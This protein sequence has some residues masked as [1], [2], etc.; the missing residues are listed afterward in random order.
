[1]K[2]FFRISVFFLLVA[3]QFSGAV[4]NLRY[5]KDTYTILQPAY[6]QLSPAHG[7]IWWDKN[8]V[9]HNYKFSGD[10]FT[11]HL[12]HVPQAPGAGAPQV[13]DFMATTF[14]GNAAV[15][16]TP[17]LMGKLMGAIELSKVAIGQAQAEI[18][19]MPPQKK[20]PQKGQL[21]NK[22]IAMNKKTEALTGSL[23]K[24]LL[25]LCEKDTAYVQ[26]IESYLATLEEA[27]RKQT[28]GKINSSLKSFVADLIKSLEQS[29]FFELGGEESTA[30]YPPYQ[31]YNI[32]LTYLYRKAEDFR[33]G[34]PIGKADFKE[35]FMGLVEILGQNIFTPDGQKL[36]EADAWINDAYSEITTQYRDMIKMFVLDMQGLD[37]PLLDR[38]YEQMVYAEL[39]RPKGLPKLIGYREGT[40]FAGQTLTDCMDTL[41]RNLSNFV[42]YDPIHNLFTFADLKDMHPSNAL[43]NFYEQYSNPANAEVLFQHDAW[44]E[45]IQNQPYVAYERIV[46]L[47]NAEAKAKVGHDTFKGFMLETPALQAVARERK[48]IV[49]SDGSSK[50][51]DVAD[52]N[53]IK[54][55]L[56]DPA[57]YAAYEVEPTIRNIIVTMN[58]L[59]GLGLY[60]DIHTA[61]FEPN[62]NTK[63][64]SAMTDKLGWIYEKEGLNLNQEE[65]KF[66]IEAPGGS[67]AVRLSWGH[68]EITVQS[69]S[70]LERA[71]KKLF[72]LISRGLMPIAKSQQL[73]NNSF[74]I[75]LFA[76]YQYYGDGLFAQLMNEV[77]AIRSLKDFVYFTQNLSDSEV[78]ISIIRNLIE[79]QDNFLYDMCAAL[80]SKLDVGADLFYL[81]ELSKINFKPIQHEKI[82]QAIA[83]LYTAMPTS[84]IILNT[85]LIAQGFL[86]L[87]MFDDKAIEIAQRA[88]FFSI[89]HDVIKAALKLFDQLFKKGKGIDKAIV[90]A[91]RLIAQNIMQKNNGFRLLKILVNN[92]QAYD[93]ALV[94]AKNGMKDPQVWEI[95]FSLFE[96]LVEQGHGYA[97]AE[98]AV[99][100][101]LASNNTDILSDAMKVVKR[102][103]AKGRAYQIALELAQKGIENKIFIIRLAALNLFEQ[104]FAQGH[105]YDEAMNTV[106]NNIQNTNQFVRASALQL[107]SQ[108]I[109]H[110]KF[111]NDALQLSVGV[112]SRND[113]TIMSEAISIYETLLEKG[114]GKEISL[115]VVSQKILRGEQ[116]AAELLE[117]LIEKGIGI[118]QALEI[119]KEA[120]KQQ[121]SRG[122]GMDLFKKLFTVGV[123]KEEAL[124]VI[125][126]EV[127][128]GN[129]PRQENA[130]ELLQHMI[131]AFPK[132]PQVADLAVQ[133][134]ISNQITP[135]IYMRSHVERLVKRGLAYDIALRGAQELFKKGKTEG[136]L[137]LYNV[138]VPKGLAY[139]EALAAATR[140]LTEKKFGNEVI[141][142][143]VEV[144]TELLAQKQLG[145]QQ[146]LEA[147]REA[148]TI[149]EQTRDQVLGETV[150]RFKEKIREQF[151]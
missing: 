102:L 79:T 128:S 69:K 139:P 25:A 38:L 77:N 55:V 84:P 23:K 20:L 80:I 88:L 91:R 60:Q 13:E 104:L 34:A 115:E 52:V 41:L 22:Q 147:Y 10:Q 5:I 130:T 27:Q 107:L 26:R 36:F 112:I 2:L 124:R 140:G 93:V 46:D 150:A 15:Y 48:S 106:K 7:P 146:A 143:A 51:F 96:S 116:G 64:F 86:Y 109:K 82:I 95:V 56:I 87:D 3:S 42:V 65:L 127:A 44:N 33:D 137:E 125:G 57:H 6:K 133:L 28:R 39:S 89:D 45:V 126:D 90:F 132:D 59:F 11:R 121:I 103:V 54:F 1:M 66:T 12:F 85:V 145:K 141:K 111:Y 149:Q 123:G 72:T 151:E 68:G 138:L 136:A 62:F 98:Q 92:G 53:G 70:K 67:F 29:G 99:S 76:L 24:E 43:R 75:N 135:S 101:V 117:A 131:I 61:F 100:Q 63:Y 113:T 31:T 94:E 19:Q 50:E 129:P 110:G 47:K 81:L 17:R 8:I 105:G 18:A 134:I 142:R 108:L 30:L 114:L 120:V 83:S 37:I 148:K 119:A 14:P 9:E 144:L 58:E 16:F 21:S 73:A 122:L 97:E 35:Y 78:K 74:L 49:F 32:M 118:P 4:I 40:L 71:Q